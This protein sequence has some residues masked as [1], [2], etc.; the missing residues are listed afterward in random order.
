MTAS[1]EGEPRDLAREPRI[2]PDA[3]ADEPREPRAET[4]RR[5][6]AVGSDEREATP[7]PAAKRVELHPLGGTGRIARL[8]RDED[9]AVRFEA[10]TP[11]E[12]RDRNGPTGSSGRKE[13]DIGKSARR[14]R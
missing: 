14:Y 2:A 3:N 7:R 12:D 9:C 8:L 1:F 13:P 11:K 5:R 4:R 6:E 10:R